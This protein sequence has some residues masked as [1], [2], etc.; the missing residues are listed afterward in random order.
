MYEGGTFFPT[1]ANL[2]RSGDT[3]I[4]PD[5]QNGP[6][7]QGMREAFGEQQVSVSFTDSL[8][9]H[10][11]QGNLHCASN[12]IRL[13]RPNPGVA[14]PKLKTDTASTDSFP[15]DFSIKE[16]ELV[17]EFWASPKAEVRVGLITSAKAEVA[18]TGTPEIKAA[19]ERILAHARNE[20][21]PKVIEESLGLA[22]ESGDKDYRLLRHFLTSKDPEVRKTAAERA[23]VV[24]MSNEAGAQL[25]RDMIKSSDPNVMAEGIELASHRLRDFDPASASESGEGFPAEGSKE[26]AHGEPNC[27][28][29]SRFCRTAS[30]DRVR[31]RIAAGFRERVG[32]DGRARCRRFRHRR[33]AYLGFAPR[34]RSLPRSFRP[35][36]RPKQATSVDAHFPVR[37]DW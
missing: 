9:L 19:A 12:S 13:C 5:P 30:R 3:L 17:D 16:S 1:V 21:D 10:G 36:R 37:L 35:S 20:K 34:P 28:A 33:S 31:L 24:P 14:L 29:G 11:A 6:M 4:I 32:R 26:T 27:L 15:V 22:H 7:R 8:E 23:Y 18:K 2:V 25:L